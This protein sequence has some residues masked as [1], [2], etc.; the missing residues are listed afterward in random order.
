[1]VTTAA[2]GSETIDVFEDGVWEDG[3]GNFVAALEAMMTVA[4]LLESW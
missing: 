2:D 1:M 4:A 3:V